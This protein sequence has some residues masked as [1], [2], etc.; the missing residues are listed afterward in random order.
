MLTRLFMW[1]EK[2][3]ATLIV[4]GLLC[5]AL[6]LQS[7][8]LDRTKVAL[9]LANSVVKA[10][11]FETE[12]TNLVYV[13]EQKLRSVADVYINEITKA[14]GASNLIAPAVATAWGNAIDCMRDEE[15]RDARQ[16][17]HIP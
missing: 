9:E 10:K 3:K 6:V 12:Q 13:Q 8:R 15:C 4:V 5:A 17:E 16:A 7:W 11:T 14:E 1:F 2:F